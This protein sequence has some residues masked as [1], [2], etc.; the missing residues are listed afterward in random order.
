[1]AGK[2]NSARMALSE[3]FKDLCAVAPVPVQPSVKFGDGPRLPTGAKRS[4]GSDL[5]QEKFNIKVPLPRPAAVA[6]PLC[7]RMCGG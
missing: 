1:M 2:S 6:P 5:L 3:S 7:R 4:T